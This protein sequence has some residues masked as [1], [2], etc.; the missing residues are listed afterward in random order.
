MNAIQFIGLVC[1]AKRFIP[2]MGETVIL[3]HLLSRRGVARVYERL[4]GK[5]LPAVEVAS[6]AFGRRSSCAYCLC[7][8]LTP[9][10]YIPNNILAA[11]QPA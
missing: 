10:W 4:A 6:K 9:L 11:L 1:L 2:Q 8:K 7:N 5:A 3:D